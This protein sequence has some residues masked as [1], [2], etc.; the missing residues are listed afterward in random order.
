MAQPQQAPQPS[1]G[2]HREGV[3]QVPPSPPLPSPPRLSASG[4]KKT[5]YKR[6]L[7]TPP[8]IEFSCPE[9]TISTATSLQD[10][11]Q[12]EVA[13]PFRG[14]Q[15]GEERGEEASCT[16][17]WMHM[18]EAPRRYSPTP[19]APLTLPLPPLVLGPSDGVASSAAAGVA[20]GL[21]AGGCCCGCCCPTA[22]PR[23]EGG[24]ADQQKVAVP[25]PAKSEAELRPPGSLKGGRAASCLARCNGARVEL[26]PYGATSLEQFRAE[27]EAICRSGE[28]HIVVS[29]SR[30]AFLQTGDGHFSPIGG[31]HRERDLVLVLDVARFKYPPT[32]RRTD[33]S[34][35]AAPGFSQDTKER[36]ID[37]VST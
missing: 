34:Q 10:P 30:K 8:A 9:A 2:D 5:F 21:A 23:G 12:S 26:R 1:L 37:N 18:T 33:T 31:Y 3:Q 36:G 28:E 14:P 13:M 35:L 27:V 29:Y 4:F 17:P 15:G 19:L 6:K 24:A 11:A 25:A 32:A 20:A 16:S 7:P 22:G